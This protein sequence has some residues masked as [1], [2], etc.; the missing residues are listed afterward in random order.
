MSSNLPIWELRFNPNS[1]TR[2][3]VGRVKDSDA[4]ISQRP[5]S[6]RLTHF[7]PVSFRAHS[8]RRSR[9]QA[10]SLASR[11]KLHFHLHLHLRLYLSIVRASLEV[12]LCFL[13]CLFSAES[14]QQHLIGSSTHGAG[15]AAPPKQLPPLLRPT[16]SSNRQ[17]PPVQHFNTFCNKNRRH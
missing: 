15:A 6:T 14:H 5:R 16:G 12:G 4:V 10:E 7:K 1:P 17:K 8:R 9:R 2:C 3:R 11:Q 13:R